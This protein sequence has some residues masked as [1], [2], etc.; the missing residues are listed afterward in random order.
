MVHK[1]LEKSS[2][3]Q[4]EMEKGNIYLVDYKQLDGIET[5]TINRQKQFLAAPLCLLYLDREENLR[6][7][8]IQLKQKAGP[9]N[10]IFLPSDSVSWL[11]AK[12]YVPSADFF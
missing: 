7:I 3:L 4:E 9:E 11:L 5:N 1:F 10:P 8:A 2:G 6:P 12:T